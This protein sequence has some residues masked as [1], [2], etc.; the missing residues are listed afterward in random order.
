MKKKKI[1]IFK[2]IF[3]LILLAILTIGIIIAINEA[4]IKKNYNKYVVV[5]VDS[6]LYNSKNK[7]VGKIYKDT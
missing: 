6:D 1:N 3:A 2:V 5:S 7:K 4:K